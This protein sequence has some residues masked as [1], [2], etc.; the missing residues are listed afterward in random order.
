MNASRWGKKGDLPVEVSPPLGPGKYSFHMIALR[1]KDGETKDLQIKFPWKTEVVPIEY[2]PVNPVVEFEV[3]AGEE[4]KTIYLEFPTVM[5]K[6]IMEGSVDARQL[7]I[8]YNGS[9]I[10][11]R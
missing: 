11:P 2:S 9:W 4:L 1:I 7:S 8:C 5:P 3:P 6:D 10:E